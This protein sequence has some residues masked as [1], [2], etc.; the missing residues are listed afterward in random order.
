MEVEMPAERLTM[1]QVREILR[2]HSQ[3]SAGREIAASLGL[4]RT[5]VQDYIA[6]A[7]VAR[8]IWPLPDGLGDDDL[9]KLLFVQREDQRPSRPPPDWHWVHRELRRKHV[10]L[11]LLWQEYKGQEL[12]GY[13]YSQFCDL[14][15]QWAKALGVWM[16]QEHLGGEKLF[17]D[18]SGD[19][20]PWIDPVT[21]EVREAALF[22]AV[23]GA[24]NYTFAYAVPT[25]KLPDWLECHLK[26][27]AFI[28]GVPKAIVPDQPKTAIK[29]SC[30]YD[31]E[32]NPAYMELA[33]H[34]GTAVIPA[35]P[36]R[37]R[38][39]AKVEVGVL[40][41]QRWVI[42]VLRN[43]TFFSVA[44]INEAIRPLLE[45]LNSRLM[46]KLRRSRRDLFLEVDLPNLQ[47]LPET[48]YQYAEWKVKARVNFDYHVEFDSNYYSVPHRYAHE[49]VDIR[50]TGKIV[51]V[52]HNQKRVASHLRSY[53]KHQSITDPEHMPSSHRAH[54]DWTPSRI[55]RWA[56]TVGPSTAMLVERVMEERPHPEQGFRAC[57]GI[58]HL[59]RHHSEVRLEKAAARALASKSHSY[60]TVKGILENRLEDQPLPS[61]PKAVLPRHG[62]VR[63]SEYYR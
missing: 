11:L 61:V 25:Q 54:A 3:G 60:R 40:L 28:G 12:E 36:R 55:V 44:E 58:I 41:A 15:R 13:Q 24:S 33:R 53:L 37:P 27:L 4:G 8:L 23:L 14:Y 1:R 32:L 57:M 20:I 29:R 46:R 49:Q 42:A 31:P 30:R 16:R 39:K 52:L 7:K 10:T 56:S 5:T 22:V 47:P 51:E 9:E 34:Y 59:G 21:G 45:K 19:G 2:L 43:R 50:A 48:T 26:A 17:V 62:N 63:G 18:F 6:R 35:R 38:D